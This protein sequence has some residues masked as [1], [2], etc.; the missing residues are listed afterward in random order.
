M[1]VLFAGVLHDEG[2]RSKGHSY[3]HNN[4]L[5]PLRRVATDVV[6][7]DFVE[8]MNARGRARMNVAFR[9]LAA[10]AHP[11]LVIIAPHT[12]QVEFDTID[13]IRRTIPCV[14]YF[15]DDAWRVEYTRAWAPHLTFITTSDVWGV[16]RYRELGVN[17]VLYSPFACNAELFRRL[18]EP[19]AFDVSF[20]GRY[21]PYR[22]W[23]LER[24]RRAGVA[25]TVRG[26]G[27]REGWASE[28][29]MIAIFN[30]SRITLNL[31]N[32]LSWDARYLAAVGRSP[33]ETVRIWRSTLAALRRSDVKSREMV[34]GR[35]FEINACGAFQLSF[36]VEGLECHYRIGEEIAV[37]ESVEDLIAKVQY[38]LRHD[39]ERQHIADAGYRRTLAEHT[40][41]HRF[42]R[43]FEDVGR[44]ANSA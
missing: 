23:I 34:K 38:Y 32:C 29:D 13:T 17:N 44:S 9:E 19:P 1:R 30:R 26:P 11:D 6:V 21:H 18:D 15:F 31:S 37:Y 12:D 2:A 33:R 43:L 24:L 8:E 3:E 4:L 14:G 41:E 7:F 27:W 22:A 40:M 42:L 5:L 16:R 36:F 20:V 35:H 25:V 10:T 39:D 28:S